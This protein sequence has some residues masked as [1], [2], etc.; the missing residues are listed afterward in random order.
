[1]RASRDA[2]RALWLMLAL[3]LAGCV[4]SAQGG[5]EPRA[6][7]ACTPTEGALA[8]GAT[9]ESAAGTYR[10]TLVAPAVDEAAARVVTGVLQL[11]PNEPALRA[12]TDAGGAA[13]ADVTVP[14]HGW[15]ETDLAAVGAWEVGDVGSQDPQRPGVLVLEQRPQA[16][17]PPAIALRLGSKANR[18]GAAPAFDGAFTALHVQHVDDAGG[19]AGTWVS[20]LNTSRVRGHFCATP[21][22]MP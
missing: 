10:L 17:G 13:R 19:F 20:G 9:L 2:G 22:E 14:L 18:R 21:T 4:S 16:S 12:L 5:D 7:A 6:G 1:M 3:A 15:L 8:T 11:V